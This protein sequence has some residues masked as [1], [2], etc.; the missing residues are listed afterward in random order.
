MG[1][2]VETFETF[3]DRADFLTIYI[4]EAHPED[5][6]QM[7]SNVDQGVCYMQPNTDEDRQAI[8]TDFKKRFDYPMPLGIDGM[9]NA[10]MLTYSAWPERLYIVEG[11]K[12]AYKGGVGPYEYYPHEV[13][14]WLEKRFEG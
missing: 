10:A 1:H 4:K 2:V 8:V 6:W 14:D 7:E 12:I 3:K 5:E 9:D 11:G 13:R